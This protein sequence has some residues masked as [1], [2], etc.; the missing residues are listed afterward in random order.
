MKEYDWVEQICYLFDK[1]EFPYILNFNEMHFEISW[2]YIMDFYH[3]IGVSNDL[4]YTYPID[5]VFYKNYKVE[6]D[7]LYQKERRW[8]K[9]I[10]IVSCINQYS[11]I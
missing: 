10:R 1:F 11:I 4:C 2:D 7:R 9:I 6:I 3:C 8:D 5:E